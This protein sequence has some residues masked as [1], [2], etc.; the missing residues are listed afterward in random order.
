MWGPTVSIFWDHLLTL[1]DPPN[2]AYFTGLL[3]KS[4]YFCTGVEMKKITRYLENPLQED[5]N[6]NRSPNLPGVGD[7]L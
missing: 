1:S 2:R 6:K 4:R 7:V 5:L 3:K